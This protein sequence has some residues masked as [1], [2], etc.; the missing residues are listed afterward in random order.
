VVDSIA[1]KNKTTLQLSVL[2]KLTNKQK[3]TKKELQKSV[4]EIQQELSVVL[5]EEFK[6]GYFYNSEIGF[7][8]IAGHLT[9]TFLNKVNERELASLPAGLLGIF[10]GLNAGTAEINNYFTHLKNDNYCLIIRGES[11]ALKNIEPSLRII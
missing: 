4:A 10:R 9:S 7:L 6:F 11:N 2:G 5:E 3:I 1:Q 8:F